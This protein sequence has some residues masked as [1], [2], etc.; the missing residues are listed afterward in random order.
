[1]SAD[2][3]DPAVG[4]WLPSEKADLLV[5]PLCNDGVLPVWVVAGIDKSVWTGELLL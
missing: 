1:M 5:W 2:L 4:S 3:P